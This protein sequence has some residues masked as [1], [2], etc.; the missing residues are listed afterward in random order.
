MPLRLVLAS[1]S[2]IR[3]ALLRRA[4]IVPEIR[5]VRI[6]EEAIRAGLELEGATP[7]ELADALA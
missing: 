1:A 2:E 4:G 3:A 5:P 6:D 7:R